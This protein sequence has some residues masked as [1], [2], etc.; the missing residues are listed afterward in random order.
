[1]PVRWCGI[2]VAPQQKSTSCL[3]KSQGTACGE[4][5]RV[6][7]TA[8]Y[9][10]S[11]RRLMAIV[12]L[13]LAVV[14][15]ILSQRLAYNATEAARA[16]CDRNVA[17][18]NLVIERWHIEKGTWPDHALTEMCEDPRYLPEGIP[19]CPVGGERYVVDS[20]THR[21]LRHYH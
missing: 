16:V 17:M 11:P 6:S 18:V 21:V 7:T 2:L 13:V 5:S 10:S 1:M 9:N 3:C 19:E 4:V 20:R 8:K 15:G 14:V 12:I